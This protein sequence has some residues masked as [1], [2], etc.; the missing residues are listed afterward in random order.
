VGDLTLFAWEQYPDPRAGE[1]FRYRQP[2]SWGADVYVYPADSVFSI[3]HEAGLFQ[4]AME[5]YERRG[6]FD[7]VTVVLEH[8]FAI[9]SLEP[10]LELFAK[11]SARNQVRN[12]YYYVIL[13]GASR[14]KVRVTVPEAMAIEDGVRGF[15]RDLIRAMASRS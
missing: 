1:A 15:V 14:V 13:L 5:Q 3:D 12:T 4:A 7:S 6:E 10:G 11:I 8:E 2:N 9:E